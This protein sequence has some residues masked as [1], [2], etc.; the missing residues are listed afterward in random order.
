M[1]TN[2]S[3]IQQHQLTSEFTVFFYNYLHCLQS[4]RTA[5]IF[6]ARF[7]TNQAETKPCAKRNDDLV[8]YGTLWHDM[9]ERRNAINHSFAPFD[10]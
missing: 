7:K 9:N 10:I 3:Q 4:H 1:K 8:R 6:V 2:T 5:L